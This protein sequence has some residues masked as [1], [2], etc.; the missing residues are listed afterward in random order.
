MNA[1]LRHR[2]QCPAVQSGTQR[3]RSGFTLIELLVVISIIVL[4]IAILMPSLSK[5]RV[6]ARG[7]QCLNNQRQV[8]VG[9]VMYSQEHKDYIPEGYTP[10]GGWP[11]ALGRYL[12]A[13]REYAMTSG[14]TR[15]VPVSVMCPLQDVHDIRSAVV[16]TDYIVTG[17]AFGRTGG[18]MTARTSYRIQEIPS[19]T[20]FMLMADGVSPRVWS[21]RSYSVELQPEMTHAV[22]IADIHLG[23]SNLLFGDGHAAARQFPDGTA[24]VYYNTSNQR[25]GK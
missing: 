2:Q 3:S 11:W 25:L 9:I 4:L 7:V 20:R 17:W 5:A 8:Y 19:P 18:G 13:Q 10:Q 16:A 12:T 21:N 1:L 15:T 24:D 6:A 14:G 23:A 22:K